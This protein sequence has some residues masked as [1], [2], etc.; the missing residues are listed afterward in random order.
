MPIRESI[1]SFK[2]PSRNQLQDYEAKESAAK[3]NPSTY[4]PRF[5]YLL[6][7][8]ARPSSLT[9]IHENPGQE[10]KK[11]DLEKKLVLCNRLAHKMDRANQFV[12][13]KIRH[14][15]S[16]LDNHPDGFQRRGS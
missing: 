3:P 12:A 4:R 13:A 5:E 1:S 14:V 9:E 7:Q 6:R 8:E 15:E 11:E 16:F 10:I 2:S